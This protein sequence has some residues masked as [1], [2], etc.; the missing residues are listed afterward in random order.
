[1]RLP[2]NAYI[3]TTAWFF[4]ATNWFKVP[5]HVFVWKTI[6]WDT[7]L[8]SLATMPIIGLGAW[9]GIVIVSQITEEV[10][11]WFI[12]ITTLLAAVLMVL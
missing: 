11:R 12:V 6:S 4:M 10:Y 3:G 7:L 1:M 8:M 2:K 9:L 5:F